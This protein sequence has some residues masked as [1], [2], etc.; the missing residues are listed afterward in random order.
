VARLGRSSPKEVEDAKGA[1]TRAAPPLEII[2][3]SNIRRDSR[4][5]FCD[6]DQ[7]SAQISAG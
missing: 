2:C 5:L 1:V 6:G 3:S 7:Q 4:P